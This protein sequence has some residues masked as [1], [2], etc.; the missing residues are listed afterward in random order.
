MV[1][2]FAIFFV[3]LDDISSRR[4]SLSNVNK[5]CGSGSSKSLYKCKSEIFKLRSNFVSRGKVGRI[6]S[7]KI[8]IYL[9]YVYCNSPNMIYLI[10]FK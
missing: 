9:T 8:L 10:N 1:I 6:S 3:L 7:K 5:L 4:H 2:I